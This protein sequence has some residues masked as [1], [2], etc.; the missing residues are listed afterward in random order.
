[1]TGRR[2]IKRLTGAVL[3]RRPGFGKAGL[4]GLAAPAACVSAWELAIRTGAV[5]YQYLPAPSAI[6]RGAGELAMSGELADATLET[7]EPVI[8]GWAIAVAAGVS[9]GLLLGVSPGLRRWSLASIE[10]LRPMPAIAFVPVALL[11]FGFSIETELMVIILPSLWPVLINT[12]GGV[13][14]LHARLADVGRTLHLSRTAVLC[15]VMLPAAL[16][17]ILVG[18]R[19]SLTL[20]LVLGVLAEMVGNPAGL[21]YAVVT[22][23]QALR[24]DLMFAYVVVIGLLGLALNALLAGVIAVAFPASAAALQGPRP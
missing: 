1:M 19:L 22:Q 23:Q 12:M 13:A 24:P 5:D 16:P 2:F 4:A 20:A 14:G 9:S 21:G 17:A 18:V 15:K 6:V 8:L 10:A 3:A 7:L 11:L